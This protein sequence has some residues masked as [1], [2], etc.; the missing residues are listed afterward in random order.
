M[1][2]IFFSS[3]DISVNSLSPN[4]LVRTLSGLV[5]ISALRIST[6]VSAF[7]EQTGQNGCYIHCSQCTIPHS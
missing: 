3:C 2:D 1:L 4:T 6:P 7:N 5:A